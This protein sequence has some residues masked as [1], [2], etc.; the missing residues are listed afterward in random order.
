MV[1]CP[2]QG[3][4]LHMMPL[5]LTVSCF[6]KILIG[7]TFL[8]PAHPLTRLVPDKGPL[9]RY[10]CVICTDTSIKEK[11]TAQTN[12]YKC[13]RK[14]S[15]ETGVTGLYVWGVLPDTKKPSVSNHRWKHKAQTL[16]NG[17]ECKQ[18]QHES[19]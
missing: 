12:E 11:S 14:P 18:H 13:R 2:E 17:Y 7:F 15:E 8:V 19:R 9:N 4:D 1:I 10:V 16:T 3:A 5:P 6:S